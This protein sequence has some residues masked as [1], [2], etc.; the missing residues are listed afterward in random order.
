MPITAMGSATPQIHVLDEANTPTPCAATHSGLA[1][2]PHE[3]PTVKVPLHGVHNCSC[4]Q[5]FS[6]L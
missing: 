2:S 1:A 3:G 5:A 6:R 4:Q